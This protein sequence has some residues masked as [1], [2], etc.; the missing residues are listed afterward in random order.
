MA[1]RTL[2]REDGKVVCVLLSAP[3]ETANVWRCSVRVEVAEEA[4]A[5]GGFAHGVDAFQALQNG[6]ERIYVELRALGSVTWLSP[7]DAGF[8]RIMPL[9]L[10]LPFREYV[11]SIVDTAIVEHVDALKARTASK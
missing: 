2:T 11:E 9:G 8:A 3:E 7:G 6:L 5:R 1:Q 4:E 10:G